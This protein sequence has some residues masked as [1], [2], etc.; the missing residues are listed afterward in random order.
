M[1][2]FPK[3]IKTKADLVNTYKLVKKGRLKKEDWLAAVEKLENQNFIFDVTGQDGY[4]NRVVINGSSSVTIKG[5][6]AGEYSIKEVTGWSC[7]YRPASS[8]KK[9]TLQPAQSGTVGFSSTPKE[10]VW[11]SGDAYKKITF[12]N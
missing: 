12:G 7:R 6:I 8:P 2:G 3:V 4:H 1:V 10:K 5:L 11:L 9:I